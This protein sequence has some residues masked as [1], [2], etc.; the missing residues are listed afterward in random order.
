MSY[1]LLL[2]FVFGLII[3][4]IIMPKVIEKLTARDFVAP[5][6]YKL[7]KTL[8]PTQGG[9]IIFAVLFLLLFINPILSVVG[10]FLHTPQKFLQLNPSNITI[11]IVIFM[12]G[13]FGVMDDF[14]DIE[15]IMK[16]ILPFFFAIPMIPIIKYATISLPFSASIDLSTKVSFL[17][18]NMKLLFFYSFIIMPLYILVV[19]NLVNMHSG[20]NGLQSGTSSILLVFLLIKSTIVGKTDDILSIGA[21]AGATLG[22]WWYNKYPAKIFVGNIGQLMI[23]ASIGIIIIV[24][25]FLISG[26]IMLIPHI[27]NFLLYIYWRIMHWRF[28]NDERYGIVKFGRV[29]DNTG[30]LTVPNRYTLKWI[31]PYHYKM[32]EKQVTHV[33]YGLTAMFC[34]IGLWINY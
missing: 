4:I 32:T 17:G 6:R 11:I 10:Q 16:A 23:G 22:L 31:L 7:H 8:I 30:I 21:V 19:A 28:P 1:I 27:A 15:K 33:M 14:L 18:G 3:T 25:G 20:F 9:L 12:Y 2:P 5:D 24:N 13:I 26:F 29:T 34:L